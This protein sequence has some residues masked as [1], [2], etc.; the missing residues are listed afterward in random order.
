MILNKFSNRNEQS[1]QRFGVIAIHWFNRSLGN[2]WE[3]LTRISKSKIS[4]ISI[5]ILLLWLIMAIFGPIIVPYDPIA[6]NLEDRFNPP[7]VNYFFGTDRYGRDVFS[8]V[9]VGSRTVFILAASATAISML[10]GIFIGLT[11][12][13]FGGVVDELVMRF[14]DIIM[15]FPALLLALMIL[16]I[17]GPSLFGVIIVIGIAFTPRIARVARGA[18]LDVKTKE[19]VDAARV[20]NESHIY[21]MLNEILPNIVG[22]LG[23]EGAVRFGYAI[24]TSA[25]L[26]FLGLGVQPPT[27]DWGMMINEAQ[28]YIK[29]APWMVVFPA[30]SIASLTVSVN[31]LSD[32]I[33][34]LESGDL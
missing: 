1:N 3:L 7:S 5:I 33:R 11:S 30:A 34:R 17:F 22:P 32:A 8:R 27:P 19:F 6:H 28:G 15:S 4:M 20:R 13:Y 12:G 18:T 21:I 29:T 26:G 10:F 24:F 2:F 14:M 16:G 9:I 25:S 31:F 23:V